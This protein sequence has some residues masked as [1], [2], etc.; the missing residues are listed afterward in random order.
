MATRFLD[1]PMY[2]HRHIVRRVQLFYFFEKIIPGTEHARGVWCSRRSRDP[3]VR[4]AHLPEDGMHA[5]AESGSL[6]GIIASG[7]CNPTILLRAAVGAH[8]L[9]LLDAPA[10]GS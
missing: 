7:R 1:M 9:A 4:D 10:N 2:G 6:H 8:A 3:C 5:P